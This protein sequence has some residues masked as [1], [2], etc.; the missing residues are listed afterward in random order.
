VECNNNQL[1]SLNVN[2]AT[3][4]RWVYCNNN[5]LTS[6]DVSGA[7]AL[8][9]LYCS[10]NQLTN[11]DLSQNIYFS[12][13]I[14]QSNQLTCLNI[15]NTMIL[16]PTYVHLTS[17]VNNPMLA[18]IEVDDVVYS[19]AN[20]VGNNFYFDSQTSF[21]TNCN[22]PCSS[23]TGISEAPTKPK[24]LLTITDILGRTTQPVPNTL[25]FYIYEDGSVEKKMLLDD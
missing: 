21:S 16:D 12:E 18:C 8:N 15:K 13:L 6:L 24:E 17:G 9:Q 20:W 5:Q 25:L 7:P 22:N 1:M 11:L 4:L 2:G 23:T 14:C 19:N 3:D 10:N